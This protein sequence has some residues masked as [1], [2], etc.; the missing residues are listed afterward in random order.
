ME[1][2]YGI[3]HGCGAAVLAARSL[4]LFMQVAPALGKTRLQGSSGST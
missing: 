4:A 1:K 2:T 3:G